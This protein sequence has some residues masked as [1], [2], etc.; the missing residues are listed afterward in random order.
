MLRTSRGGLGYVAI[1]CDLGDG[2]GQRR[3]GGD[4]DCGAGGAGKELTGAELGMGRSSS[5]GKR[6][7][8]GGSRGSGGPC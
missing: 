5:S 3:G 6:S 1:L 2:D 8:R 7:Q 4:L